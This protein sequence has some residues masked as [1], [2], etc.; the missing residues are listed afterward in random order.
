VTEIT[1]KIL[2]EAEAIQV[3]L[4]DFTS[5]EA[6]GSTVTDI[7]GAG[8]I[9]GGMEM[10]DNLS[11]NAVEDVVASGCYPRDAAAILLVE[12]DGLESEVSVNSQRVIAIC[13]KNGARQVTV[14]TDPH[15]RLQMWK[16]RKAAFAAM[17]KISPN[18]YVQ[19]GVIPRT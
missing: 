9:P 10:M 19:D 15:Q 14:A 12:L 1:L 3:L 5:V 7:I 17:G 8:I 4:A 6:A 2:K 16:G 18:Y 11:I 13:Q